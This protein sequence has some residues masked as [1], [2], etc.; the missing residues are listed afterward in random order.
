MKKL[1]DYC[2]L[3]LFQA[4]S[5]KAAI[6]KLQN[7]KKDFLFLGKMMKGLKAQA[8]FS[9]VLLVGYWEPGRKDQFVNGYMDGVTVSTFG[10]MI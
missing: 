5:Q 3:L 6:R 9:S 8:V 1:E 2:S 4:G 7:V 10:S